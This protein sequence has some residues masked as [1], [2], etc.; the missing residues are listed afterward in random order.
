MLRKKKSLLIFSIFFLFTGIK[1]FAQQLNSPLKE[2]V[3]FRQKLSNG[4]P[5]F[6]PG[7][8]S[9]CMALLEKAKTKNDQKELAAAYALVGMA[10]L[11]IESN[12]KEAL[13]YLYNAHL[14]FAKASGN[15]D[16]ETIEIKSALLEIYDGSNDFEKSKVV[17]LD[18]LGYYQRD[19]IKYILDIAELLNTIGNDY[20]FLGERM[21]EQEY[22]KRAKDI[23][24]MFHTDDKETHARSPM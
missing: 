6:P 18:L 8:V 22:L 9:N 12:P 20:G 17:A 23:L 24:E 2:Y 15:Y 7:Y 13:G 3:S 14:I 19:S 11:R 1:S 10:K 16:A 5:E 4:H 21:A